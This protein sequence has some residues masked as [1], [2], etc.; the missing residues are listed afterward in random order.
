[1]EKSMEKSKMVL[2]DD[3]T[4]GWFLNGKFHREDGPAFIWAF[5][6]EAWFLDGL[7]HREDGPQQQKADGSD[8]QYTLCGVDF[9]E[10]EFYKLKG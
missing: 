5:G 9:T 10:E 3:G 1:M 4:K 6:A 2:K 8:K 7:R